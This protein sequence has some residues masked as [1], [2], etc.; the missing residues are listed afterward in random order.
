MALVVPATALAYATTL[1]TTAR[2]PVLPRGTDR[3]YAAML[4]AYATP[5]TDLARAAAMSRDTGDPL[6]LDRY[7]DFSSGGSK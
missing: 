1:P 6:T 5:G 4:P 3:A 7:A 2:C